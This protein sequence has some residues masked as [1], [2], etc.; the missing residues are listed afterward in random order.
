[1]K[2]K[3][4]EEQATGAKERKRAAPVMWPY[5]YGSALKACQ[6]ERQKAGRKKKYIY[7][8]TIVNELL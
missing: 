4:R 2:G 1:M 5:W 6:A 7:I 8:Y 3:E